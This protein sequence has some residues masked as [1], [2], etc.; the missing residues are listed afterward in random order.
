MLV[1]NY[2]CTHIFHLLDFDT[3]DMVLFDI[4]YFFVFCDGTPNEEDLDMDLCKI[5]KLFSPL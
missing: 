5:P 4:K 2:F 1:G 3:N